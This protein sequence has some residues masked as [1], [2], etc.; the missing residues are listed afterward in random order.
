MN[1]EINGDTELADSFNNKQ[2]MIERI[3]RYVNGQLSV[4][5]AEALEAECFTN[6]LLQK[7]LLDQV[8]FHR[9]VQQA[10]RQ[11]GNRV[12][13][14]PQDT[15]FSFRSV[16]VAASVLIAIAFASWIYYGNHQLAQASQI[17]QDNYRIY[18]NDAR[19]SGAY[20]P[21]SIK[22]LMTSEPA[23]GEPLQAARQMISSW[24]VLT[25]RSADRQ[26]L[27][28]QIYFANGQ[29]KKADSILQIIEID[30]P[31]KAGI[32]ND[33]GVIAFQ[34]QEWQK[35]F[36]EFQLA[37][38]LDNTL[39]EAQYNL[40]LTLSKLSRSHEADSVFRAYLRKESDE[41]WKKVTVH[42]LNKSSP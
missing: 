38:S 9:L 12:F 19:L 3:N 33:R 13:S 23:T 7:Q 39:L 10:V 29:V 20:A 34:Q 31:E 15:V 8:K 11:A 36:L 4:A 5:E 22:E 24:W 6:P 27:L 18:I 26:R 1:R 25:T 28:A 30:G 35:A 32:H 14:K 17:M 21:K 16:A 40:A 42:H 41:N 37:H 2:E